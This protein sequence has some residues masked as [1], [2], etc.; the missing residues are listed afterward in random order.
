MASKGSKVQK[1][2]QA[3]TPVKPKPIIMVAK[4]P[5]PAAVATEQEV[6]QEVRQ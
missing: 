5:A 4:T 3:A 6:E 1:V 2:Q